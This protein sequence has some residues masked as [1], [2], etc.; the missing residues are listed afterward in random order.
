MTIPPSVLI[1][2]RWLEA[3]L[4]EI[5]FEGWTDEAARKVADRIALTEGERALAA[6]GGV[7]DLIDAFFDEAE[8]KAGEQ[9]GREE[10]DD[11]GVTQ[12]VRRGVVAWLDA[13]E[14]ERPAVRRAVTRA[15]LP[16]SSGP[17]TR[18]CWKVADMVWTAAGD[19][20]TDYNFYSKRALLASV[21][22]PIVLY[23]LDGP[24]RDDLDKFIFDRLNHVS[25]FGRAA[26]RILK[27]ALS[28]IARAR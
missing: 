22:P 16:W 14:P 1:R 24:S 10:P 8:R 27:P 2:R 6:P 9:L 23:W 19:T 25:T 20:S 17:A 13:L 21:I 15:F 7:R 5:A 12:R 3:L 28:V 18:R 11:P 26:G 4:P